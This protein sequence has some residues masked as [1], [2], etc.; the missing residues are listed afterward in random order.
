M[1]P[2]NVEPGATDRPH[3][4]A[5]R[6][7]GAAPLPRAVHLTLVERADVLYGH[8]EALLQ[9]VGER[10]SGAVYF[11]LRYLDLPQPDTVEAFCVFEEGRVPPIAHVLDD[12]AGGI[13]DLLGEKTA[14]TAQSA[15]YLSRFH[16]PC[17]YLSNQRVR[18]SPLWRRRGLR[19]PGAAG[20]RRRGC[21]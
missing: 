20:G 11:L 16:P 8:P 4:L 7:P 6:G 9:V 12:A 18:C 3:P 2:W 21:R 1:P 17:V 14:G 19:S 13:P 5:R 15:D 10:G